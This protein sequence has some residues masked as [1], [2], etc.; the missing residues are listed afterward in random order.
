MPIDHYLTPD[1]SHLYNDDEHSDIHIH[2]GK[3]SNLTVFRTHL[4]VLC[5]RSSYFNQSFSDGVQKPRTQAQGE[6][7]TSIEAF[8]IYYQDLSP[9]AFGSTLR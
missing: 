8:N 9:I 4:H 3:G 6:A 1:Y 5:K 7:P 2:V